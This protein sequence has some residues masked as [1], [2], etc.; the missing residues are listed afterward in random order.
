MKDKDIQ[1]MWDIVGF[2]FPCEWYGKPLISFEAWQQ[3]Y[4]IVIL[5]VMSIYQYIEVNMDTDMY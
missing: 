3:H 1:I 4:M 5:K 2:C